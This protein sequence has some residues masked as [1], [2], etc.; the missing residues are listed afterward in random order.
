MVII[1]GRLDEVKNQVE[2]IKGVREG[3]LESL[4]K[5]KENTHKLE[6]IFAQIDQIEKFI[7]IV[8]G[9]MSEVELKVTQAEKELGNN[10]ILKAL[11][12]NPLNLLRRKPREEI[13]ERPKWEPPRIVLTESFFE[14]N[15]EAVNPNI[16]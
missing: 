2:I 12:G 7:E 16:S 11:S 9:N 14:K 4:S 6:S 3:Q 10:L 15:I 13:E 1:L 5:L 8:Q